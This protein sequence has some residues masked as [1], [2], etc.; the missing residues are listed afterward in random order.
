MRDTI[1]DLIWRINPVSKAINQLAFMSIIFAWK[2]QLRSPLSYDHM[3]WCD[4]IERFKLKVEAAEKKV[5][6]H[7]HRSR[8][9]NNQIEWE[10]VKATTH[11]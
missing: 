4:A 6:Q 2:L 11:F 10:E 8:I 7:Q 9:D 5:S 3:M 1:D